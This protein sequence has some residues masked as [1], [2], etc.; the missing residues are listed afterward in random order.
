MLVLQETE[1]MGPSI[2][3]LNYVSLYASLVS[4]PARISF[5]LYHLQTREIS[6][7][8]WSCLLGCV[9]ETQLYEAL[10]FDKEPDHATKSLMLTVT[11]H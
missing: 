10:K 3:H 8:T 11:W 1:H 4:S 5:I 6:S 7:L 2:H 9:W